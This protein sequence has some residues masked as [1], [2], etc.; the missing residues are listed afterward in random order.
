MIA[1]TLSTPVNVGTLTNPVV[2]SSLNVTGVWFSTTPAIAPLGAAELEITLT[3]PATGWQETV[4][5]ND[6]SVVAF[7]QTPAPAPP[8]GATYED[9]MATAVFTK[10]IADGK[11]PAGTVQ[12]A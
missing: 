12:T 10:L 6:A 1:F 9:V 2:V 7:F 4:T 8:T 3:D 5:Y 11:L